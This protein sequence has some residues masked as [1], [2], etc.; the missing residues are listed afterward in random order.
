MPCIDVLLGGGGRICASPNEGR[1]DRRIS[2]ARKP[3]SAYPSLF[4]ASDA[5]HA[6]RSPRAVDRRMS[7]AKPPR[8]SPA[9]KAVR[10]RGCSSRR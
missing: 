5:R 6:R 1:W 2:H 9:T 7:T 4:I 10:I 3:I 8:R